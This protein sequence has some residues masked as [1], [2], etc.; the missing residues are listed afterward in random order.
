MTLHQLAPSLPTLIAGGPV[1]LA[2]LPVVLAAGNRR[3]LARIQADHARQPATME[4]Q[5]K[6]AAH[7]AVGIGHRILALDH[8]LQQLQRRTEAADGTDSAIAYKQAMR[9]FEQGVDTATVGT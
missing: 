7:A 6:L 9:F 4:K 5:L 1:L 3:Q 8:K 2:V